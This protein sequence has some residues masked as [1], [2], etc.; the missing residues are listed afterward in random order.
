M[1]IPL[2]TLLLTVM[3]VAMESAMAP[4]PVLLPLS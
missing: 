3:F 4:V 1:T 2:M